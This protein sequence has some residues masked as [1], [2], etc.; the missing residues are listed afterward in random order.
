MK[1]G[2]GVSMQHCSGNAIPP[3]RAVNF[4][5]EDIKKRRVALSQHQRSWNTSIVSD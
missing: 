2:G 1:K 5:D 4:K 3:A